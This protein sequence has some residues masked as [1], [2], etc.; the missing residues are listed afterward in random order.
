MIGWGLFCLPFALVE[1]PGL[2]VW[3]VAAIF[4]AGLSIVGSLLA[5][6]LRRRLV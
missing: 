5:R 4:I 3:L 2:L 6:R 1:G